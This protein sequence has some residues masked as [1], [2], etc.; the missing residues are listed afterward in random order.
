M[1]AGQSCRSRATTPLTIVGQ[2]K[3]DPA[4][5]ANQ[6]VALAWEVRTPDGT[7]LGTVRQANSVP[8]GSLE[9][10]FGNNALFA[11]QA[12]ARGISD[13]VTRYR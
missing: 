6:K 3:L 13:L 5:G 7:S 2:V 12:A 8:A 4:E 11:A 9:Q 10:G 1:P